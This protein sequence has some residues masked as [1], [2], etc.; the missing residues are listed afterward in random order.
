MTDIEKKAVDKI[1]EAAGELGWLIAIPDDEQVIG[2]VIGTEEYLDRILPDDDY[3]S[4]GNLP[5]V[6]LDPDK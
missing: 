4:S 3:T 1:I 2:L 5:P 6:Y